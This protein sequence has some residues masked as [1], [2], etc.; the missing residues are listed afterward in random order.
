MSD[1]P[2]T[3]ARTSAGY[4]AVYTNG[5][6]LSNAAVVA[7]LNGQAAALREAMAELTEAR[8]ELAKVQI[9]AAMVRILEG[10]Y[11]AALELRPA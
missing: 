11:Y 2:Y 1:T 10:G 9:T 6:E 7:H 4:E 5:L 3:L 8:G